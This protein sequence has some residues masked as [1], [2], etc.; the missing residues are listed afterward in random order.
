MNLNNVDISKLPA[1][2]RKTFR[3]LQVMHAEKKIQN[4]AKNDFLSFVKCVWPEFVE[5]PH[6]RHIAEKF[7]KLASGEITRLIVNMPPRHT[8]SEFAS[9]LLPAW[10]V[11]RD[12]KLKIIQATHTGELAVRFGRKAKN[13]IDSEDYGKIFKTRLQEDSKAAGRWETAQG[14]EYFA[15]GV[16]GAI[17]GR[18]ADLLII[19][20][21][22]SE[23]D[24]LSP[25]AMESAYEWYTSGPRQRLQPGAK[26][27]LVMTRWSTKDLTGKLIAHQKEAKSDQWD[28]VEFPAIMDHG[29]NPKPVWPQYWKLEEL[30]KV[31]ATLP[32]G[33]WN[34]QW[35]Q[36][37]TSEEGAIIKREWWMKYDHEE[38]PPLHHV[39]QSYDTA[40]LKKE[41]A[42]CSAITTWG[43]FYPDEDSAP[44]LLLLDAIKGRYEFPELR[45]LAL[46]QY[47]YWQPESVIIEAKAS[48]L[49]LTY[50][51]RQMDIPVVNFTPSKGNDKHARVN[52]VAPL[53][54]SGMIY[55]PEQ[56]FAEEV[57]EECA[58]FPFGDHD[59]LV[60]S[61]TQAIMR[62]RQGGLLK[63]P[64]DYVDEKA[65]KPKRAYY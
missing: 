33:K 60:D 52:A 19:D 53:F 10:M 49:P 37:P 32:V 48:G 12:P 58:S 16:G 61:T 54:E 55:A 42:D 23:Q 13:L 35:M 40:F 51:L 27:V 8:K 43:V 3:K 36:H 6:H 46:E 59:D 44:A 21:P 38:I 29:T 17:T 5:G 26:I 65:E 22:H 20:D 50:E 41:T 1:D 4:K 24:A 30:E 62:F 64:E 25:T 28:V 11:G 2:V 7:N 15:A 31:K 63:H 18:G 39:I 14:G 47:K 9:Y 56:K 34:A 45:R 57:I